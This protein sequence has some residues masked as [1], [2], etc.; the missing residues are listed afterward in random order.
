MKPTIIAAA[1]LLLAFAPE[2]YATAQGIPP[3]ASSYLGPGSPPV[4]GITV[5]AN[6]G[7]RTPADIAQVVLQI[8]NRDN[9][10]AILPEMVNP[11]KNALVAAHADRGS[12]LEPFYLGGPAQSSIITLT[13]TFTHPAAGAI[14]SAILTLA[15]GFAQSPSVYV[16]NANVI[17]TV[18]NCAAARMRAHRAALEEARVQAADIARASGQTLGALIAATAFETNA[19]GPSPSATSCVSQY[20]VGQYN[21]PPY[22]KAEDFL[23]VN[24]YSNFSATFALLPRA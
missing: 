20:Q 15:N 22:T 5:N 24:V 2:S 10:S 18:Q 14:Q 17:L 7:V 3:R 16:Q 9:R 19:A 4:R 1:A 21:T 6:A 8:G 13:A 11:I 12:V 23:E